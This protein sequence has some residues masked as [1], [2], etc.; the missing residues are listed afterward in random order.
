MYYCLSVKH[1][2]VHN[3]DS[4]TIHLHYGLKW[5][6]AGG[7]EEVSKVKQ[8]SLMK[9]IIQLWRSQ[10]KITKSSTRLESA[11]QVIINWQ[12]MKQQYQ[13]RAISFSTPTIDDELL[14]CIPE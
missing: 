14:I 8:Q 9:I 12:K 7:H 1:N 13:R 5:L 11:C 4:Q 3:L 2:W 6:I 10:G